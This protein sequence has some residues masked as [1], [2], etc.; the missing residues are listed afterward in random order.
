M[1]KTEITK[2]ATAIVKYIKEELKSRKEIAKKNP[3]AYINRSIDFCNDSAYNAKEKK[4]IP[5]IAVGCRKFESVKTLYDIEEVSNEV[6]KQLKTLKA[7]RGWKNLSITTRREWYGDTIYGAKYVLLDKVSLPD[8]ACK[9]FVSLRNYISKYGNTTINDFELYSAHM[10]GKRGVLW[11]EEG[12]R[13][14]LD[15]KPNKCARVLEELRKY[16]GSKDIMTCKRGEEDYMDEMER[17]YSAYHEVECDGEKR[18][19]LEIT[20]K[21]PQGKV[22]YTTKIY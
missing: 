14:Y 11:E 15:N 7:T 21:S 5:Y 8:N 12:D 4:Y 3:Y 13:Y 1:T 6:I 16:R 22:K 19:Y 20:I 9:E 18:K 2:T 17:R 10:G